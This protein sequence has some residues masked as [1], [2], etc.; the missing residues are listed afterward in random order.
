MS[1]M[2]VALGPWTRTIVV[3][4]VLGGAAYGGY[5]V[6]D[7]SCD[8]ATARS[9]LASERAAHANTK[10]DLNAAQLAA[11]NARSAIEFIEANAEQ[12]EATIKKLQDEL[13]KVPAA[14]RC[15]ITPERLKRFQQGGGKQ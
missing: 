10:A 11:K 8:A 9:Q 5:Y 6:R 2:S 4:F 14:D 7:Q 1:I 15:R 13:D 12:R 3:A